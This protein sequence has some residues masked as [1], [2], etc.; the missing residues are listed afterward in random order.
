MDF[1]TT[2]FRNKINQALEQVK[3]VLENNRRPKL[4]ENV[5]HTYQDKYL[6]A[7][8]VCNTSLAAVINSFANIGISGDVLKKLVA[9]CNENKSVSLR[10]IAD[11]KCTFIKEQS[12]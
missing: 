9:W 4:P 3:L 7:E 12:R 6:L 2:Q 11:E 1:N 10:F 8:F 5:N